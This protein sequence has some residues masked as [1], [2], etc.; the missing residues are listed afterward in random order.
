MGYLRLG[1][2]GKPWTIS[3]RFDWIVHLVHNWMV[4]PFRKTGLCATDVSIQAM[5][6]L[7]CCGCHWAYGLALYPYEGESSKPFTSTSSTCCTEG[8]MWRVPALPKPGPCTWL[9]YVRPYNFVPAGI[10]LLDGAHRIYCL[11]HDRRGVWHYL[12][13]HRSLAGRLPFVRLLSWGNI[14]GIHP[15]QYRSSPWAHPAT[16][17]PE[18]AGKEQKTEKN[19]RTRR[20]AYW[21]CNC[22]SC[23][24]EFT[25]V[26]LL[27]NP[28]I[29]DGPLD[30]LHACPCSSW[31]CCQRIR[32][33][34]C[35]LYG[36]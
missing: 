23:P 32:L 8:D 14:S 33:C 19:Y 3:R 26:V 13:L 11:N 7:C 27:I 16:I 20:N 30:R 4:S 2:C 21:L 6:I 24:C 29:S 28:T 36:W 9:Q 5:D 31:F 12:P 1:N 10:P 18:T 25:L 17:R 34:S 15:D 22:S 35:K